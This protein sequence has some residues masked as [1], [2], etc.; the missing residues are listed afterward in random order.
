MSKALQE[1]A[2]DQVKTLEETQA[3][4]QRQ[5]DSLNYA[6]APMEK[7]RK[8]LEHTI[9]FLTEAKKATAQLVRAVQSVSDD[10]IPF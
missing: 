9:H 1:Y 7:R 3:E 5:L 10:D 2:A 4:L 8:H 6:L